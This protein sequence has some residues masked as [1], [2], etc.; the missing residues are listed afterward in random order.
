MKMELK[1]WKTDMPKVAVCKV[2]LYLHILANHK[3]SSL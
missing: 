1:N 3:P 2:A